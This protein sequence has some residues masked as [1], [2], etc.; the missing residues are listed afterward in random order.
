M[1]AASSEKY[2]LEEKQRVARRLRQSRKEEW[3]PRCVGVGVGVGCRFMQV[4]MCVWV[5]MCVGSG[6]VGGVCMCMG[7]VEDGL[8]EL[9]ISHQHTHISQH[10]CSVHRHQNEEGA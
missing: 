10:N 3:K 6:W 8:R 4:W 9:Y 1:D 5:W 2:R 7:E